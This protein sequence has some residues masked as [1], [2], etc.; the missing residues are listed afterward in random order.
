MNVIRNSPISSRKSV[1]FG[2]RI[3]RFT[4]L[5][6]ALWVR[7]LSICGLCVAALNSDGAEGPMRAQP[8]AANAS[9]VSPAAST[10]T[11]S[12]L[13]LEHRRYLL[14]LYARVNEP[15]MAE[16]LAKEILREN[17]GDKQ[18]L[19]ALASMY[20]DRKDRTNARR[21]ARELVER[22]PDDDQALY[23]AAAASTLEGRF[24]E[25]NRI[26]RELKA[27][28]FS[29]QR[30]PYEIDLA[31]AAMGAGDWRQALTSYQTVLSEHDL[32][33]E[34]RHEVRTALDGLHREHLPQ[35]AVES[36]LFSLEAG[37][38]SRT[39]AQFMRHLADRFRLRPVF[40]H[41]WVEI[42]DGAL[43][44]NGTA[45]RVDAWLRLH[46][47]LDSEWEGSMWLGGGESGALGG[48][49]LARRFGGR[50]EIAMEAF[51]N[52]PAEDGLLLQFLDGRE[53]RATLTAR[54]RFD[55]KWT[56]EVELHGRE[57]VLD[58][59]RLSWGYGATWSVDHTLRIARPEIRVGLHGYWLRNEAARSDAAWVR[60]IVPLNLAPG[61]QREIAEGLVVPEIHRH[62]LHAA[63]RHDFSGVFN[64]Q[65][66]G[67]IE[68]A[69][70]RASME[71][72]VLGGFSLYA[73]RSLE[74][75][76]EAGYSS[77]ARTADFESDLWQV[78]LGLRYWF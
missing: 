35:V 10:N 78:S 43:L 40:R 28:Q 77:S 27:G 15:A 71:Y 33:D 23:Y 9:A 53:H 16:M 55:S 60:D 7:T 26:L 76:L 39:E 69:V 59:E 22:Y 48:A 38:I 5:R 54:Y 37:R 21:I 64:W 70:D 6:T 1:K 25:A 46:E 67:G 61:L 66:R 12:S 34:L 19:L 58:D 62:G 32:T 72:F 13:P 49:S 45:S 47:V 63:W 36:R 68:Y 31:S 14:Y 44:R 50:G 65:T 29:G 8:S 73:R 18:T 11:L 56:S 52:K 42:D 17:P 74:A 2:R 3:L 4:W 75:R 20:V 51:A 41:E 57:S 30:F 24:A